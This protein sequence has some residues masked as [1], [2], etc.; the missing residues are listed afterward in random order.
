MQGVIN[1]APW[2][3]QGTVCPG[4]C[5]FPPVF[6]ALADR[7]CGRWEAFTCARS[8]D[9]AGQLDG[10]ARWCHEGLFLHRRRVSSELWFSLFTI[11]Q[12]MNREIFISLQFGYFSMV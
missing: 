8:G 10:E 3:I 2:H 11:P 9:H 6:F 4:S 12:E 1:T 5:R 7:K